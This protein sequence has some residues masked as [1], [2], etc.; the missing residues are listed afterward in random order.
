MPRAAHFRI[1]RLVA[2]VVATELLN[3]VQ[4]GIT[5][6]H[7]NKGLLAWCVPRPAPPHA[8]KSLFSIDS[9]L[10]RCSYRACGKA[11]VFYVYLSSDGVASGSKRK[12]PETRGH[13]RARPLRLRALRSSLL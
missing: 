13:A 5:S 6:L 11:V 10:T 2:I 1:A 9:H 4:T 8:R 3:D 7:L 12:K